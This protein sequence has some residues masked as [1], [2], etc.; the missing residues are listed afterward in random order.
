[1]RQ[2][3]VEELQR[4][5]LQGPVHGRDLSQDVDAV[6]VLLDHALQAPDLP[7]DAP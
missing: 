3:V 1:M 6:G 2:V 7:F 5:R 4:H